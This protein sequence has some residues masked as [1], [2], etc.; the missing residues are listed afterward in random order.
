MAK[1]SP[2]KAGTARSIPSAG[3]AGGDRRHAAAPPPPAPT[4]RR[5][6]LAS[7][8]RRSAAKGDVVRVPVLAEGADP[9]KTVPSALAIRDRLVIDRQLLE[10]Y[11]PDQLFAYD[12]TRTSV[13][14]LRGL[15]APG[16]R[17]VFRRGGR[18]APDRICA[19]RTRSGVVLARVRFDGPALLLLPGPADATAE[20]TALEDVKGVAG[21]VAGTH[22]LLIRR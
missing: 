16:D 7:G 4:R 15:A 10:D 21:V 3:A 14:H 11:H 1:R 18:V 9:G 19:V 22:V 12:V 2:A 17:I 5:S 13:A 8:A 20:P 6:R